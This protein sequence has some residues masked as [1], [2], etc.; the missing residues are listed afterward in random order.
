MALVAPV[1]AAPPGNVAD[2]AQTP[3]PGYDWRATNGFGSPGK[4]SATGECPGCGANA[5]SGLRLVWQSLALVAP[6]SAAPPGN[7]PDA[8]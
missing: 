3:Y 6:V 2:A 8:A 7:V 1:S 5:L 4:R